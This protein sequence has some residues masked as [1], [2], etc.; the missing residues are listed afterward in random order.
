VP[1][2]ASDPTE[3]LERGAMEIQG[4]MPWSSN[5]T[6]LVTVSGGG[7]ELAAL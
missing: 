4:R 3:L 7:E 5:G 1:D 6:F 2:D